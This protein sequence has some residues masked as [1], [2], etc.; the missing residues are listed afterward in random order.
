MISMGHPDPKH[1]AEFAKELNPDGAVILDMGCGTGLVGEELVKVGF[2][3]KHI[4]G[5]D[6]S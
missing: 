2:D 4:W 6:A 5:I 3:P 1:C